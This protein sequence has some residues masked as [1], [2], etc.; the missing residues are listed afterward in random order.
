MAAV[1]KIMVLRERVFAELGQAAATP[2]TRVAALAVVGNPFAAR[3]AADLGPLWRLGAELGERLMPELTALLGAP[4]VSY[5]KGAVVGVNGETE[6]GGAC[7]HPMLGR[8]MRAADAGG[9]RRRARGHPVQREGCGGG[10]GAG[11]A[12]RPQ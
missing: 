10:R 11:C 8:P 2:V 6:H 4:A 9:D 1:R 12:A 5:G 3:F 7:V